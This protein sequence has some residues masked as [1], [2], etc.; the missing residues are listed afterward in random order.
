M[1]TKNLYYLAI[2]S[3]YQTVK[4]ALYKDELQLE[5]RSIKKID[6]S[7]D[8][9]PI[10]DELC[11]SHNIEVTDFSFIVVNQ[12]PAPF[13]TLRVVI[14]TVN[15]ICSATSVP[16]IGIDGIVALLAEQPETGMPIV[17]VLDAFAGDVYF[18]I[19]DGKKQIQSGCKPFSIVLEELEQLYPDVQIRLV[20]NG[21]ILHQESIKSVFGDR[22]LI[23]EPIIEYCSLEQIA[24]MGLQRFQESQGLTE[25]VVPLYLKKQWWQL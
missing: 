23:R 10:L 20:G 2:Q 18:G 11:K 13:T 6:A 7:A 17:A 19:R 9:V 24:R 4:C 22:A 25:Q 3:T 14:A 21:V 12:G 1:K 5:M 8:L 16:L 15:G